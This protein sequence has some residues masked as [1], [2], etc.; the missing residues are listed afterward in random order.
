MKKGDSK[1][2]INLYLL[3]EEVGEAAQVFSDLPEGEDLLQIKNGKIEL[4]YKDSPEKTPSWATKIKPFCKDGKFDVKSSTCG[5]VLL[6]KPEKVNRYFALCFGYGSSF[7]ESST[8][9]EGFGLKVALNVMNHEKIK[10]I[11]VKNLD[12][13]IKNGGL[14][15]RGK[16]NSGRRSCL[17][18]RYWSRC[19]LSYLSCHWIS[20]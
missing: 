13:I 11:D 16:R 5:A 4:Y 20:C 9:E 17:L 6:I 7:I 15:E 10:S 1:L 3:K 12:T 18:A 8:I 19:C 2:A 14:Y